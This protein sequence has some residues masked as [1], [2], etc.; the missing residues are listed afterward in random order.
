MAVYSIALAVL[1]LTIFAD[2]TCINVKCYE[3]LGQRGY[4]WIRAAI[5][6]NYMLSIFLMYGTLGKIFRFFS[7][8]KE[9]SLGEKKGQ[10][11]V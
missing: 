5:A 8:R 1:T 2:L 10:E 7:R 11:S 3:S 6:L 9:L 4:N